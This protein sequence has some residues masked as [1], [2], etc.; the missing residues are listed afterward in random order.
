MSLEKDI[1]WVAWW[2]RL[3]EGFELVRQDQ[4]KYVLTESGNLII[5]SINSKFSKDKKFIEFITKT[6]SFIMIL[7]NFISMI[8]FP[9]HKKTLRDF[10]PLTIFKRKF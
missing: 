8:V 2:G 5:E 1:G 9:F 10:V 4:N 6:V 7:L 3:L